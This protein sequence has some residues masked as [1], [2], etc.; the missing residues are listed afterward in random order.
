M[1]V[2]SHL[3]PSSD[4]KIPLRVLAV[5]DCNTCGIVVPAIGNT[6]LDKL[7]LRLEKL[8]YQTV[9]QNLGYG[10]ATSREGVERIRREAKPADLVLINFGLVDTW[11]TSIPQI[12]VPYYPDSVL[13]KRVRKLLKFIKR[14]LRSPWLRKFIPLGPVVPLEEYRR[15]M[16]QMITLARSKN[17]AATILL[18]GSPP[19]QHDPS[20]NDNLR[21]Y[22]C[23]LKEIAVQS[24]VIFLSTFEIVESLESA[25]A[26]LD[27]VHLNE[28]ATEGI[29]AA[30]YEAFIAA[31]PSA[32]AS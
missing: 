2:N 31:R 4:A 23:V 12:Y 7:C 19:V 9:G 10:M 28:A 11:I 21:R 5:G 15:N 1:S 17:P 14:R 32:A 29:A 3:S 20:R 18:W 16:Q 26:Y 30:M 25:E 13:R 22:D 8:G 27:E 24:G 6:I